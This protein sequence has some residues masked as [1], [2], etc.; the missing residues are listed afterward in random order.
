M[1]SDKLLNGLYVLITLTSIR[2]NER[3]FTENYNLEAEE[4]MKNKGWLECGY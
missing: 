3:R 2:H 1:N 4:Y